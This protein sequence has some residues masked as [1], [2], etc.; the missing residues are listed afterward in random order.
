[1]WSNWLF[2]R[3]PGHTNAT[4]LNNVVLP[5]IFPH[6]LWIIEH[7]VRFLS[8]SFTDF[9]QQ[10]FA[11]WRGSKLSTNMCGVIIG[12][13]PCGFEIVFLEDRSSGEIFNRL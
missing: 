11:A 10:C 4:K 2:S 8:E 12:G 3:P 6:N 7:S 13:F 5:D 1:M 9:I